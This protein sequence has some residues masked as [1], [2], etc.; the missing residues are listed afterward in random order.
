MKQ[1]QFLYLC[2]QIGSS[3]SVFIEKPIRKLQI[4]LNK[5]NQHCLWLRLD[6]ILHQD[7]TEGEHFVRFVLS[8]LFV[9]VNYLLSGEIEIVF[10]KCV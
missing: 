4:D 7:I 5:M 6:V 10:F 2:H 9:I 3:H 8:H 1:I